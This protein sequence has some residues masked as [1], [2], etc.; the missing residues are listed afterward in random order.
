MTSTTS[1]LPPTGQIPVV[2]FQPTA[3]LDDAAAPQQPADGDLA[4]LIAGHLD[5]LRSRGAD[6]AVIDLLAAEL[7]GMADG[8]RGR[9]SA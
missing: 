4:A 5:A 1:A 7:R 3:A 9:R 8:D 2:E 6:Q